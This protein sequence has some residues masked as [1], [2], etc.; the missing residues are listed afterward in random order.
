M[1]IQHERHQDNVL[2]PSSGRES[3][4]V[5]HSQPD[6]DRVSYPGVAPIEELEARL[7]EYVDTHPE[8]PE[9]G[10]RVS[11][12]HYEIALPQIYAQLGFIDDPTQVTAELAITRQSTAM[13]DRIKQA[14]TLFSVVHQMRNGATVDDVVRFGDESAKTPYRTATAGLKFPKKLTIETLADV[15]TTAWKHYPYVPPEGSEQN[16]V[17]FQNMGFYDPLPARLARAREDMLIESGALAYMC[18]KARLNS[19]LHSWEF[20]PDATTFFHVPVVVNTD[21]GVQ[22]TTVI[23]SMSAKRYVGVGLPGLQFR[24]LQ[25]GTSDGLTGLAAHVRHRQVQ[26]AH[27]VGEYLNGLLEK[28]AVLIKRESALIINHA[29]LTSPLYEQPVEFGRVIFSP[30]GDM[31]SIMEES[32]SENRGEFNRWL[33]WYTKA[34]RIFSEKLRPHFSDVREQYHW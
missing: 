6:S 32:L 33:L 7:N 2:P 4:F 30:V 20:R 34:V 24:D 17:L 11:I 31:Q 27:R 1:A 9:K 21:K 23:D 14:Y 3:R 10:I 5:N 25:L 29:A 8:I 12:S 19:S 26:T 15:F 28:R 16:L 22:F 13:G 18:A